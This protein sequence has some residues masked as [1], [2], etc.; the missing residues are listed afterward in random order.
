MTE[1]YKN[2]EEN[3]LKEIAEK[4]QAVSQQKVVIKQWQQQYQELST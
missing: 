2:Q 3:L 4:S 1:C